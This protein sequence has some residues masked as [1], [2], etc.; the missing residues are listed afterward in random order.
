MAAVDDLD[1][2]VEQL[3]LALGEFMKETP[4][5]RRTCSPIETM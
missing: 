1:E 5:L 3:R 4:S 2:V